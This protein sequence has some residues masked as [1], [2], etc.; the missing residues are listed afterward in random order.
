MSKPLSCSCGLSRDRGASPSHLPMS[1]GMPVTSMMGHA[2]QSRPNV[3]IQRLSV[4]AK[5]LVIVPCALSANL[6]KS[7]ISSRSFN[8]LLPFVSTNTCTHRIVKPAIYRSTRKQITSRQR[9][10]RIAQPLFILSLG[11]DRLRRLVSVL[12]PHGTSAQKRYVRCHLSYQHCSLR[13]FH[14]RVK[15]IRLAK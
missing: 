7:P 12:G 8:L 14:L 4:C 13:L 11:C 6:S 9:R 5:A 3:F 2:T 1:R 10:Q 15:R